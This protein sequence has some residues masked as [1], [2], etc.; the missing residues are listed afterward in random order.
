MTVM[1]GPVKGNRF[2]LRGESMKKLDIESSAPHV[3]PVATTEPP[4]LALAVF[5]SKSTVTSEQ[6]MIT[7]LEMS[8]KKKEKKKEG[9]IF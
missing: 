9:L 4:I 7:E 8:L 5:F 6:V 2:P 1:S 3:Q